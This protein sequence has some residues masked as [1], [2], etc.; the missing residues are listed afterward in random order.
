MTV[1]TQAYI[2]AKGL[3]SEL[4]SRINNA[5]I[6]GPPTKAK[7]DEFTN[8]L[9]DLSDMLHQER[10][11][12]GE[13]IS[14]LHRVINEGDLL[15][16]KAEAT[17][18]DFADKTNTAVVLTG[19]QFKK[20]LQVGNIVSLEGTVAK[21]NGIDTLRLN[22]EDKIRPPVQYILDD[23]VVTITYIELEIQD[24]DETVLG[25][26]AVRIIAKALVY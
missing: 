3:I 10:D 4:S 9:G 6:Y 23:Y 17:L 5:L 20:L 14:D 24:E 22:D 26:E 15:L 19:A 1:I 16:T 8:E 12:L 25:L 21:P 2:N 7:V 18:K 11:V 13:V